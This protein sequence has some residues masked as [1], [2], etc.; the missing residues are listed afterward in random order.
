[1]ETQEGSSSQTNI[2]DLQLIK[3]KDGTLGLTISGSE[4]CDEPIKLTGL[5]KGSVAERC[6]V[7]KIGD[8]ILFINGESVQ[9]KTLSEVINMLQFAKKQVFLKMFRERGEGFIFN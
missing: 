9:Q 1:M 8:E 5:A 7:L 2:F 3:P 4:D 6:G